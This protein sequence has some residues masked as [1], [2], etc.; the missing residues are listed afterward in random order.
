MNASGVVQGSDV[1]RG[2][3]VALPGR[4]RRQHGRID[5]IVG[6]TTMSMPLKHPGLNHQFLAKAGMCHSTDLIHIPKQDPLSRPSSSL[7]PPQLLEPPQHPRTPRGSHILCTSGPSRLPGSPPPAALLL[8]ALLRIP[9]I[10]L[11]LPLLLPLPT[12]DH[13]SDSDAALL[14]R[15]AGRHRRALRSTISAARRQR[16]QGYSMA[17]K[18]SPPEARAQGEASDARQPS[19]S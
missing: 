7:A 10:R 19:H 11:D 18:P 13:A 8:W 15:S 2:F 16:C 12:S 5:I 17:T 1:D 6:C 4:Q 3:A 9:P 14:N